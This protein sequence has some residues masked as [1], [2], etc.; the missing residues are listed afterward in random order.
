MADV[1][2]AC[3][4]GFGERVAMHRSTDDSHTSWRH[5]WRLAWPI[6]ISN[7]T[8]PLVGAVDVAM[9]GRLDDPAFIGGVGLGMMLFNAIYFGMGFLRMGTTGLVAQS[10]G[11]D[12]ATQIARILVRGLVLAFVIGLS[13]ILA[14]PVITG[15]AAALFSASPLVELLMVD[16]ATI[17]LFCGTGSTRQYGVVRGVIWPTANVWRHAAAVNC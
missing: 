15:I 2:L 9:M 4:Q 6:I 8:V 5:I 12:A 10:Q 16:Y 11:R 14:A 3:H 1:G 7:V 17:R 13:V